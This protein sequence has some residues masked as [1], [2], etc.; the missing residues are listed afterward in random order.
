M[1]ET[2]THKER[3]HARIIDEAAGAMRL[4]GADGISVAKLMKR[5]GL[6]HG[7]FYAHF[8]S[9]DALVADAVG[10]MLQD[11]RSLVETSLSSREAAEG[12]CALID[13]YLSERSKN[14][15]ERAC[16]FPGLAG[17][18]PRMPAAAR[19]RFNEGVAQFQ[20][21]LAS[22]FEALGK[23]EPQALASSVLA[24]MVGAMALARA[25]SDERAGNDILASSRRLLKERLGLN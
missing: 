16:P 4:Y 22:A 15:P 25:A 17:A 5:A 7:G 9:R 12:V 11:N 13:S 20:R 21:M 19:A 10:R 24:E 1:A 8:A 6:T 18:A 2:L 3:T 14:A 23:R